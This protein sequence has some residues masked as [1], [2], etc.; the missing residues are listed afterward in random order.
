[1]Q[2]VG[3]Q[4]H[5]EKTAV[6]VEFIGNGGDLVSVQMKKSQDGGVD[7]HNAVNKAKA[8]MIQLASFEDSQDVSTGTADH[9]PDES[10]AVVSMRQEQETQASA[11][12]EEQLDEGLAGTFPASDPVATTV[13]TIPG[14]RTDNPDAK[15]G[16]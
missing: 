9:D 3:K 2:V 16:N 8:V 14:G 15:I 7:R 6:T 12:L 11:S 10:P 4:V 5:D 13:S 1:M